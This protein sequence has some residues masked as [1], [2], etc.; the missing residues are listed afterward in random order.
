M[1]DAEHVE[2]LNLLLEHKGPVILSGYETELYNRM[3]QGWNKYETV[4]YSQVCSKKREV[5]WMNY[6]PP[7]KQMELSL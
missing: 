7:A 5:I 2:L 3:L 1:S 4:S 6:D